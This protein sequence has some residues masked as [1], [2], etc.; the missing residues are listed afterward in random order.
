MAVK[1]QAARPS[2]ARKVTCS[3]EKQEAVKQV[4]TAITAAALAFAFGVGAVEP[5][6]ADVAGLTPCSE[7]KAFA[8][9]KKNEVKSLS[10]RLKQVGRKVKGYFEFN[11]HTREERFYPS[12]RTFDPPPLNL[13]AV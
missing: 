5:A 13:I 6:K 7:S 1:P 11:T 3:A 2:V 4:G 8:K 12:E 9:R 10:K